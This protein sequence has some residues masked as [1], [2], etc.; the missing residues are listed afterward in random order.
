MK[1]LTTIAALI[2]AGTTTLFATQWPHISLAD[3]LKSADLVVVGSIDS[4][5]GRTKPETP[6]ASLAYVWNSHLTVDSVLKGKTDVAEIAVQ[7]DEIRIGGVPDYRTKEKRI[8]ILKTLMTDGRTKTF[9]TC[10]RPDTVL[11]T[12]KLEE[13]TTLLKKEA[14]NQAVEAIGGPRPPQPHR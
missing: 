2:V 13:V 4:D 3:L 5:V 1:R 11:T 9:W 7:W 8:W 12:N 6:E 10:G 14:S